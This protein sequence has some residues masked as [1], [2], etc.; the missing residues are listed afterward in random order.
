MANHGRSLT[1]KLKQESKWT[2]SQANICCVNNVSESNTIAIEKD[3]NNTA[4]ECQIILPSS[5]GM[6]RSQGINEKHI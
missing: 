3:Y 2:H 5:G 1:N 6:M 4:I